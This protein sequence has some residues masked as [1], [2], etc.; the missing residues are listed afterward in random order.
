[1]IFMNGRAKWVDLSKEES[2]LEGICFAPQ[3]ELCLSK[4]IQSE[5][6]QDETEW[7]SR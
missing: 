2:Q 3:L 4:V 1:M 6:A 7:S 5:K